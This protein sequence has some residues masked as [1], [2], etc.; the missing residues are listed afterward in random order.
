MPLHQKDRL[1]ELENNA[2]DVNEILECKIAQDSVVKCPEPVRKSQY[3]SFE[4]PI[5]KEN[6]SFRVSEWNCHV[7]SSSEDIE[8]FL[9]AM[10][11][12]IDVLGICETFLSM[13]S[14]LSSYIFPGYQMISKVRN[15][16]RQGGLS[17]LLKN[18]IKFE[19][20]DDLCLWIEGKVEIFS[21]EIVFVEN[22][23]IVICLVYKPPSTPSVEFLDLFDDY[24]CKLLS[25]KNEC[26]IM[27]DFNFDL[28]C[29]NS[30]NFEFFNLMLSHGYFPMNRL[31]SRITE[32][33]ATLIDNVF[34][35]SNLVPDSYCDIMIHPGSDHLPV[36]C[37][38]KQRSPTYE[39][40][41]RKLIRDLR[42]ANLHEFREQ[43]SVI[44]WEKVYEEPDPSRALNNF[45]GIITPIFESAC[46]LK[47]TRKK[48]RDIPRKPWIDDEVVEAI[49]ARNACFFKSLNDSSEESKNEY[50]RQRNLVNKLR[51]S[52]KKKILHR[53]I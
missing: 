3:V 45:L 10:N 26:I 49:N 31:P 13:D 7:T 22:K 46:P 41:R 12:S 27:G 35:P 30:Y 9:S 32:H 2:L 14:C 23:K 50:I 15:R 1:D 36:S 8:N 21:V 40:S 6:K 39:K 4:F 51:R 18:G 33:S 48:E 16:M 43:I 5:R 24:L 25:V 52:K 11:S 34:L 20:R 28:L 42:P 44:S 47:L 29:L 38:I 37:T 19:E 53:K 17:F